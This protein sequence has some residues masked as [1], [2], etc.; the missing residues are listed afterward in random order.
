MSY[1]NH[2]VEVIKIENLKIN[3]QIKSKNIKI[4][5]LTENIFLG[6]MKGLKFYFFK[7][8]FENFPY[9]LPISEDSD[10]WVLEKPIKS[11]LKLK[12]PRESIFILSSRKPNKSF[13]KNLKSKDTPI[14]N[15]KHNWLLDFTESGMKFLTEK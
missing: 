11:V 14:V 4:V 3:Q 7:K 8:E 12:P 9:D 2:P 10:F 5:K 6:K 1:L 15:G 13:L